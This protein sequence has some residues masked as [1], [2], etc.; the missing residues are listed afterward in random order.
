MSLNKKSVT[1]WIVP[2]LVM[3]AFGAWL[4]SKAATPKPEFGAMHTAEFGRLPVQYGGR[5]KPLDTLARNSLTIVSD[6][7]TWVD[8]S[9]KERPAIDWLLETI[10]SSTESYKAKVFRIQNPQVLNLLGLKERTEPAAERFRYAFVEFADKLQLLDQQEQQ[11]R[12]RDA[13]QRDVLDNQVI[14]LANRIRVFIQLS[15]AHRIVLLRNEDTAKQVAQRYRQIALLQNRDD[16]MSF[17]RQYQN[18]AR[19]SLPRL[20]PPA[21]DGGEWK[22]F[23][24]ASLEAVVG[25]GDPAFQ[26][27]MVLCLAYADGD[28]KTFNERLPEYEELVAERMPHLATT[29]AKLGFEAFFNHFEPFYHV[30]ILYV[31]AFLITIFALLGWTKPLNRTAYALL[32]LAAVVHTFAI[33]S[34]VYISGYPPITNLYGTAIFIGW[35]AV[36]LGLILEPIYKLGVGLLVASVAGFATLLIAHFLSGDGDTMEMMQAVLDTKFWLATHVVIINLGYMATLVAGLMAV[37]FLLQANRWAVVGLSAFSIGFA[38]VALRMYVNGEP[39]A[40]WLMIGALIVGVAFGVLGF[41]IVNGIVAQNFD[42]GTEKELGRMIYGVV[43]FALLMSFVG[44]VLGGLWADDSWGRFWGWDPKENGALIIVLWNAVILHARW[45]GMI[46]LRGLAN[47]AIFGNVVTGWSWFGVNQL[48]VGLHSYGF[49]NSV[50]FWLITFVVSQ[51]V[52]IAVGM[53]PRST[54][55][56]DASADRPADARLP[57]TPASA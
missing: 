38:G 33:A 18:L 1:R 29:Q 37:V 9:G 47:L 49:T 50:A 24:Q 42:T 12:A 23:T 48:G 22:P 11:A 6:K 25:Q 15:E 40:I 10:T 16:Q 39:S 51:I 52:L 14:M 46:K 19:F 35:G 27:M 43:C 28:A 56:T 34:R 17:I 21:K 26:K 55:R 36:L 4:A 30:S 54:W 20:I 53:L 45:G 8:T 41:L 44:T 57:G 31:V 2:L 3:A 7:Q 13:G 5:V 32:L